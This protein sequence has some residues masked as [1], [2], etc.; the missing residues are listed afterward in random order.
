MVS[1]ITRSV[2]ADL[3]TL[4]I[5]L[6]PRDEGNCDLP[7]VEI[8]VPL[9]ALM[10]LFSVILFLNFAFASKLCLFVTYIVFTK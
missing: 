10:C 5:N 9:C 7:Q 4:D 8:S 2:R 6:F 1:G 3:L